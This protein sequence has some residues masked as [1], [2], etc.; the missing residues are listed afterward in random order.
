MSRWLLPVALFGLLT[1]AALVNDSAN[2][3]HI[4]FRDGN[5]FA[6]FMDA[7]QVVNGNPPGAVRPVGVCTNGVNN[8]SVRLAF[9]AAVYDW[10]LAA[11]FQAFW[12]FGP[13]EFF[14]A[15]TGG[16]KVNV[17]WTASAPGFCGTTWV[18]CT[19]ALTLDSAGAFNTAEL[20]LSSSYSYF[21]DGL[22]A[23]STHELGHFFGLWEQYIEDPPS[24][25][26]SVVSIMETV[27]FD[28]TGKIVDVCGSTQTRPF[29]YQNVQT[30]FNRVFGAPP[31]PQVLWAQAL[32]TSTLRL[33]FKAPHV[34]SRT[35]ERVL[36]GGFYPT[37]QTVTAINN[38]VAYADLPMPGAGT[39]VCTQ[40]RAVGGASSSGIHQARGTTAKGDVNAAWVTVYDMS[41][42]EA[43]MRNNS[44]S[45]AIP[46]TRITT[47]GYVNYPRCAVDSYLAPNSP[48]TCNIE[49]YGTGTIFWWSQDHVTYDYA[50]IP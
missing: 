44:G 19:Y 16:E 38:D 6:T 4:T 3:N 10:N 37:A 33:T 48:R 22:K 45:Q 50:I 17:F 35:Y 25:N 13:G 47:N 5:T 36:C 41:S 30:A 18:G 49:S 27:Q 12:L 23:V 1:A 46:F 28:A 7:S 26:P 31:A 14:G 2:A 9:R 39:S 21:P 42:Q 34:L 40:L 11:G 20:R 15:C 43:V 8:L 32:S 24:C 29:D